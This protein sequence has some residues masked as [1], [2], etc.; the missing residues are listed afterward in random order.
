MN[1]LPGQSVIKKPNVFDSE[2]R[3]SSS[4]LGS[5]S[6]VG[7]LSSNTNEKYKVIYVIL[8]GTTL[9]PPIWPSLPNVW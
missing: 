1:L 5:G 6:I 4:P 7:E 9:F 2:L 3:F 8:N